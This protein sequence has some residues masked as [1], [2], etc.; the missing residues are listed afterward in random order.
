MSHQDPI[1]NGDINCFIL[2]PIQYAVKYK[3][4]QRSYWTVEEVDLSRDLSDWTLCL[5]DAEREL[6]SVILTFFASSDGIVGENLVQQFSTEVCAPE[7]RCFYGFQIMIENVHAEMYTCLLQELITDPMELGRLFRATTT[8]LSVQAKA[9]WCLKWFDR[10]RITFGRHLIAFVIVEGIFFSSS[11]ATI[12]W[13][14]SRGILLGVCHSNELIMRDEGQHMEFACA[15]YGLICEDVPVG[16]IHVM[17]LEAVALEQAFFMSAL[18][19]PLRG[20][21]AT[22]MNRYVEY[23]ADF[24]L[25]HLGVPLLYGQTNPLPFMEGTAI[26]GR[27]NFFERGVSDYLGAAVGDGTSGLE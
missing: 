19:T 18:P 11:F 5:V 6:L 24:L 16:V 7:A 17:V 22:L 4:S 14:K 13:V 27:A 21:N 8:I 1:L 15:L 3:D 12:F 10:E 26:P 23:V 9:E 20:L 25:W 2:F